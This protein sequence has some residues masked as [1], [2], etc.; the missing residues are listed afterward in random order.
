[1]AGTAG[2]LQSGLILAVY[3]VLVWFSYNRLWD[4]PI[5]HW[6]L[7][8]RARIA[9]GWTIRVPLALGIIIG[10][11]LSGVFVGA[12]VWSFAMPRLFRLVEPLFVL[13]PAAAFY[14]FLIGALPL[15]Q[16]ELCPDQDTITILPQT[17][18]K[19]ECRLEE[20]N[21][22]A[23]LVLQDVRD[24]NSSASQYVPVDVSVFDKGGIVLSLEKGSCLI[25]NFAPVLEQLNRGDPIESQHLSIHCD[26]LLDGFDQSLRVDVAS[27]RTLFRS[28]EAGCQLFEQC[29]QEALD[30][31]ARNYQQKVDGF[32]EL[33]DAQSEPDR[34]L[35]S[36]FAS[37][38]SPY[39]IKWGNIFPLHEL[40]TR[41]RRAEAARQC[42]AAIQKHLTIFSTPDKSFTADELNRA[43]HEKVREQVLA[44]RPQADSG[45][46]VPFV[47][48]TIGKSKKISFKDASTLQRLRELENEC[49]QVVAKTEG[50]FEKERERTEENIRQTLRALADPLNITVSDEATKQRCYALLLAPDLLSMLTLL[51]ADPI[52]SD[53]LS[54]ALGPAKDA[55]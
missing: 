52:V 14:P 33:Y 47:K 16:Y 36:K 29:L 42:H 26:F 30:K 8:T 39:R 51:G 50:A 2:N 44:R 38:A 25:L 34:Y 46:T 3:L 4:S 6:V 45:P 23:A 55:R 11:F 37:I 54:R 35:S 21:F 13:A 27:M 28:V 53:A 15:R 5:H 18:G 43:F 49:K 9:G 12:M 20:S 10:G 41:D 22:R 7:G 19:I 24:P 17:V 1:V 32:D 48:L 40:H 31:L